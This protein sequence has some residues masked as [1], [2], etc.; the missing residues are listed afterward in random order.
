MAT[1]SG[2]Q[3]CANRIE[4]VGED[5]FIISKFGGKIIRTEIPLGSSLVE[6][7]QVFSNG[8]LIGVELICEPIK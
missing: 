4:Q 8:N 2:I 7:N 6:I 1:A 5:T 3:V